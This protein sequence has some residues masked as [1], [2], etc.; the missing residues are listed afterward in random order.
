MAMTAAQRMARA[1]AGRARKA[2]ERAREQAHT[3]RAFAAWSKVDAELWSRYRQSGEESD[4][5]AWL[6]NLAKMPRLDGAVAR[7]ARKET[8]A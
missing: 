8:T 4:Y 3:E 2:R 6:R 5:R 1:R 7:R